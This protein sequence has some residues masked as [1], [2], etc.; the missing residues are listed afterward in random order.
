MNKTMAAFSDA[1]GD[2]GTSKPAVFPMCC[3]S[4]DLACFISYGFYAA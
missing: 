3:E 1:R 2:S 4:L